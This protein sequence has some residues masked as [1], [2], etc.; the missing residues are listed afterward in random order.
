MGMIIYWIDGTNEKFEVEVDGARM[1]ESLLSIKLTNG[2]VMHIP[3]FQVKY[4]KAAQ[5]DNI[6]I[7]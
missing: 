5:C 1:R 2:E 6:L 7:K 3:L 4:I